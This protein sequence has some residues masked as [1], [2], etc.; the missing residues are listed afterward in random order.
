L[1]PTWLRLLKC[2]VAWVPATG[3]TDTLDKA[4]FRPANDDEEQER[5]LGEGSTQ[6]ERVALGQ[7]H[8]KSPAD[9][10]VLERIVC[11][12]S[13]LAY[14]VS[15]RVDMLHGAVSRVAHVRFDFKALTGEC[16]VE[17]STCAS[18]DD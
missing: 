10:Y 15:C 12:A 1:A 7:Q 9:Q 6:E 18:A 8:A 4:V 17:H 2:L 16:I 5:T 14:N 13:T 3:G 11:F